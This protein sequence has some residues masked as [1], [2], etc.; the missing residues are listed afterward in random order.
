[1]CLFKARVHEKAKPFY[2]WLVLFFFIGALLHI[3][4]T[5]LYFLSYDDI[6]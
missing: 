4:R 1:M 2:N 6:D 3:G 5:T